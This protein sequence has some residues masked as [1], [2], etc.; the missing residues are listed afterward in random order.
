[1]TSYTLIKPL[2]F[3]A[4]YQDEFPTG[5][6]IRLSDINEYSSFGWLIYSDELSRKPQTP[7]SHFRLLRQF[8]WTGYTN[9]HEYYIFS[10]LQPRYFIGR[11][12]RFCPIC[13][14]GNAYYKNYWQLKVSTVCLD[15]NVWLHDCCSKCGLGIDFSKSKIFICQCGELYKN[16]DISFV[17]EEI[18]SLQKFILGLKNDHSKCGDQILK[19]HNSL[20]FHERLDL[21]MFFSKWTRHTGINI[22]L[23]RMHSAAS[24]ISDVAEALFFGVSGFTSFLKKLHEINYHV[25][26]KEGQLFIRFHREFYSKF[27]QSFYQPFRDVIESYINKYWEKPLNRRNINFSKLTINS[28][29]WIPFKVACQQYDLHRSELRRAIRNNLIRSKN[30]DKDKRIMVYVY[31]PDLES[32]LY[33]IKDY[34]TAKEAATILGLTKLQF[35]QLHKKNVF[36]IA[37]APG[38]DGNSVWKFSRDEI[39]QYRDHHIGNL[40]IV[41]GDTWSFPEILQY[42]GGRMDDALT[43]LLRAIAGRELLPV[44]LNKNRVGFSS[45]MFS[46]KEFLLWYDLNKQKSEY[47]TIPRTAKLL[48][49]NQEFTYQLINQ[50]YLKYVTLAGNATRWVTQEQVD[51]FL[52]KY[53][54]LSKLAKKYLLNSR[55]LKSYLETR[56][57]YPIDYEKKFQL[58]QKVYEKKDLENIQILKG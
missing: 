46:R 42:F 16:S 36:E 10:K 35:S 26:G 52:N 29:P 58:R 17:S 34:A 50:G 44:A 9:K 40:S 41:D 43:T 25:T 51:K 2:V 47:L 15:H 38:V 22:G 21:I 1:M 27:P 53:I 28:H 49:V 32:R 4:C 39:C 24:V 30:D 37:I 8:E 57:I 33:R 6:L 56:E 48:G 23:S 11:S 14:K 18:L 45:M 5:Y 31:R 7:A 54:L 12:L 3:P 55:V 20:E 13:F 19:T